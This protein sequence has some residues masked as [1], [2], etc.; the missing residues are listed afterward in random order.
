MDMPS[1]PLTGKS[2]RTR[3]LPDGAEG[4]FGAAVF[5]LDT[6]WVRE[7]LFLAATATGVFTGAAFTLLKGL[8]VTAA[9]AMPVFLAGV[10]ELDH[11]AEFVDMADGAVVARENDD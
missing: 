10:L 6:G 11:D 8:G 7:I 9:N 5:S 4:G 1:G 2:T 3:V